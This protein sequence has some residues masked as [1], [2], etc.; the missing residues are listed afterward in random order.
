MLWDTYFL[1]S[2]FFRDRWRTRIHFY[3][4]MYYWYFKSYWHDLLPTIKV[5]YSFVKWVVLGS[6]AKST[7]IIVSVKT[8][9][10]YLKLVDFDWKPLKE[11][12]SCQRLF[13]LKYPAKGQLQLESCLMAFRAFLIIEPFGIDIFYFSMLLRV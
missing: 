12:L 13:P 2:Y 1:N 5:T 10:A 4:N 11:I 8:G 7:R 9:Q 3:N 6:K